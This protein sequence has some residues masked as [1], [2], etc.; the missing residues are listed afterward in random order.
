[1]RA[2]AGTAAG[3]LVRVALEHVGVPADAAQHVGGEKPADRSANDES[4]RFA[5]FVMASI[6]AMTPGGG[7]RCAAATFWSI[8]SGLVA[9]AMTL[10]VTGLASSQ[11]NAS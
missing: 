1:M 4:A 11:P 3:Q 2:D 7:R 6:S 10:P 9:P 8:C 5:H